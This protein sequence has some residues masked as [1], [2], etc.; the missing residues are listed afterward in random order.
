MTLPALAALVFAGFP[1]QERLTARDLDLA[2]GGALYEA[3]CM[4]CHGPD[5]VDGDTG[6]MAARGVALSEDDLVRVIINGVPDT[7]MTPSGLTAFEAGTVA[8]YVRFVA[9]DRVTSGDAA[10][11]RALVFGDGGCLDCHAIGARGGLIAPEL[12]AIGSRRRSGQ[13]RDSLLE[14]N[15]VVRTENR[16]VDVRLSNGTGVR[17]RL[18][19]QDSFSVQLLSM[20]GRLTS[21]SRSAIRELE[22]IDSPMPSYRERFTPEQLNDVVR[23]LTTLR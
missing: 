22:F 23:F 20:D 10:R 4:G 12:T 8:A 21:F 11:G 13:L 19:N 15:A 7:S 9:S 3:R 18:L 1:A 6:D 5:G 2:E 14:P 16:F 17:G